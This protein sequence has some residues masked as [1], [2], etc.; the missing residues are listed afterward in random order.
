MSIGLGFKF[1]TDSLFGVPERKVN[2]H[3]EDSLGYS[4]TVQQEPYRFFNRDKF[5]PSKSKENLYGAVP[6]LT[7]HTSTHD[8]SMYWVNSAETWMDL[9]STNINAGRHMS[10]KERQQL[11]DDN[12]SKPSSTV[13][14]EDQKV[15][16]ANFVSESGLIDVFIFGARTT[17]RVNGPKAIMKK[18][19]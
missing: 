3:L 6:Y 19:S 7:A 5:R 17:V 11:M 9:Y 13:I 2:F 16:Y 18:N 12:Q 8:V 4:A 1:E 15:S 10:K 14:N